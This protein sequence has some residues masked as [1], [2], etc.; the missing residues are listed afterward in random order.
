MANRNETKATPTI[1]A[2]VLIGSEPA[3][4]GTILPHGLRL[5]FSH[6]EV[7]EIFGKQLSDTILAQALYHGLKQ[8]LVDAA[9]ISR[10]PDTGR[11]A[12]VADKYE[13][14]REVYERLLAG[15]WNKV[16]EGGSGNTGGLLLSALVRMYPAKT[17][18]QLR[19]FLASKDDTQK[20]ALRAN[21]KIAA[22]IETIKAERAAKVGDDAPDTD[23]ML[24]ELNG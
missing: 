23:A 17:L 7:L 14:V 16:R 9:A 3:A 10:N 13:A 6:G 20:A 12:T 24:D 11:S 15:Q 21:P 19:E 1:D 4:D 18:E 22:I 2:E 8:K 5:R